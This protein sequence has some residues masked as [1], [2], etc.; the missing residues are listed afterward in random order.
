[1]ILFRLLLGIYAIGGSDKLG[2][3][4]EKRGWKRNLP[5]L[6]NPIFVLSVP[7]DR[8]APIWDRDEVERDE[9]TLLFLHQPTFNLPTFYDRLTASSVHQLFELAVLPSQSAKPPDFIPPSL[10]LFLSF[11]VFLFL[12]FFFF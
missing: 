12:F 9:G 11:L 4:E 2:K 5:G 7:T 10:F 8:S 1:M 3:G 6:R